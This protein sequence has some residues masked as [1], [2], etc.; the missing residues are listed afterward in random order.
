MAGTPIQPPGW[1][2]PHGY[3][4]A[5]RAHGGIVAVAGQIAWDAQQQ[6]VPGGFAAQFEQALAN[7]VACVVAAGG[8]ADDLISLT[9]FV[10][11]KQAYVAA[12]KEIGAAYRRIMGKHFPA[13]AL[14][15]V[16]G[17]LEPGAVVEIQGLASV[18]QE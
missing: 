8:D 15:E 5:M 9:I 2:P 12:T 13:M 14:V 4:N 10:T 18:E 1:A 17:L 16:K 7:V 11:D 3:S 6:L